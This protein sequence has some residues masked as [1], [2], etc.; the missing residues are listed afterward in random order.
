MSEMEAQETVRPITPKRQRFVEEYLVDLNGTRA[1]IR[2][3]YSATAAH[4]TACRLLKDANVQQSIAARQ[5]ELSAKT[6]VRAE[7][8]VARLGILSREAQAARQYAASIKAT[9]LQGKTLGIFIEKVQTED[10][11]PQEAEG[12]AAWGETLTPEQARAAQ[13]MRQSAT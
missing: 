7:D 8:I 1:A 2:A 12:W 9:E 5:T 3:G 13:R 11:T 10:L 6:G 4:V